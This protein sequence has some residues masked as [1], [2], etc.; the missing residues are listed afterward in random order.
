MA[1]GNRREKI[2]SMMMTGAFCP[3][4]LGEDCAM[5]GWRVYAWVLLD[6]HYHLVIEISEATPP[7]LPEALHPQEQRGV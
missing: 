5:T 2:S 3:R 6:Y 7:T 4:A 1:R